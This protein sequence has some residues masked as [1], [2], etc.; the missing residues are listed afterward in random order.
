M[1]CKNKETMSYPNELMVI[2]VNSADIVTYETGKLH[3]K[4]DT[5]VFAVF[6]VRPM[7]LS[8]LQVDIKR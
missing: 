1:T 8:S 6:Y 3:V 4:Y 7:L 5:L 2:I